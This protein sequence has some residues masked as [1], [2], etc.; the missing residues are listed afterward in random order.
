[1]VDQLPASKVLV[2]EDWQ[3]LET[4]RHELPPRGSAMGVVGQPPT[5]LEREYK[6]TQVATDDGG[7]RLWTVNPILEHQIGLSESRGTVLDLGCGQG[8]DAVWLAANGWRVIAVDHLPDAIE[9]G[10]D[11][12]ARY[13]PESAIQWEVGDIG[14]WLTYP[15][16]WM[17]MA[18]GPTRLL[19]P[20][21]IYAT[22]CLVVGFSRTHFAR[23]QKPNHADLVTPELAGA[24]LA[25]YGE[26]DLPDRSAAF[27]H[28]S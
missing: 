21:A 15:S 28:R 26:I 25:D 1:V 19:N 27:L 2:L 16:D 17:Y 18:Y 11:L 23:H 7:K 24:L 20:T 3:D 12:Q 5:W 10:K 8:R 22:K 14:D 6:I 9:R 13:A 4:R